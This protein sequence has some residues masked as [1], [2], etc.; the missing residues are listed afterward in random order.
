MEGLP[1]Y[2]LTDLP[3]STYQGF[4]C[5]IDGY[6]MGS[7]PVSHDLYCPT[8]PET[9]WSGLTFKYSYISGTSITAPHVTGTA[10]LILGN[11]PNQSPAA[12]KQII[13]ES[14]K[15]L[16]QLKGKVLTGG[17]MD[18]SAVVNYKHRKGCQ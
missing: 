15:P 3:D 14:T 2:D 12:V 7:P 8:N 5:I 16:P 6:D 4:Q 10:A 11:Q 9:S 17:M 1:C 18:T 13:L